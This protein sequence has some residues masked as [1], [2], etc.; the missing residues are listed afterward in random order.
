MAWLST[1]TEASLLKLVLKDVG[2][3]ADGGS[4]DD[5]EEREYHKQQ[6]LEWLVSLSK[7]PFSSTFKKPLSCAA[8][9]AARSDAGDERRK[10]G[11]VMADPNGNG[12]CSLAE[13]ETY[14]L[15]KLQAAY[16][17]TGKGKEIREPGRELFKAFRPYVISLQYSLLMTAQR[18]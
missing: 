12:L 6:Q 17:R 14:I 5:E 8:R 2:V 10:E 1:Y 9:A 7:V 3:A 11:F 13:L 18:H 16:P 15:K 4:R